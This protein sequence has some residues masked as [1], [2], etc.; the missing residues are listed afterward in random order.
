LCD[1]WT[2]A[3]FTPPL[4]WLAWRWRVDRASWRTS[5]PLH[6][7]ACLA[8]ALAAWAV[9]NAASH[10]VAVALRLPAWEWSVAVREFRGGYLLALLIVSQIALAS[11]G[12]L[13]YRDS[14]ERERRALQLEAQLARA[15]LQVLRMQLEPHFLFN[16]LNAIA[17]LMH[18]DVETAE[19]TLM[20][21]ADL[22]R[23]S[24]ADDG[25]QEVPLEHEL[26]FVGRYLEIERVRLGGRL[27]VEL[28][29]DA[30]CRAGL[31][32]NLVLHPLIENAVRHGIAKLGTRGSISLRARR[33]GGRLL[34]E[35][36]NDG[37]RFAPRA[38]A[39]GRGIGL[40]NTRERLE[41][42][43]P[44]AHELAVRSTA[45]GVCVAIALPWREAPSALVRELAAAR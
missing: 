23:R 35:V 6:V 11:Q 2:S 9:S 12:F 34:L 14:V 24:L 32:P 28:D 3:L 27:E 10:V 30:E 13:Y 18:R 38:P 31:V 26:A 8:A 42:L 44:G 1:E 20:L 4:L 25:A 33:D 36:E 5:V 15:Q 29:V 37:P 41:R 19:R 39:Q 16:T 45:R 17:T 40:S 22:L 43:H 7:A 21:L